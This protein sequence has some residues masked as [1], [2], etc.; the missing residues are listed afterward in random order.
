[1][2]F[3]HVRPRVNTVKRQRNEVDASVS[4]NESHHNKLVIPM[5][6]TEGSQVS[7]DFGGISSTSQ[8]THPTGLYKDTVGLYRVG[9]K[10][11]GPSATLASWILPGVIAQKL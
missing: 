8:F 10:M 11:V 7:E 4:K 2:R 9:P 5:F 3:W 6:S 1:M